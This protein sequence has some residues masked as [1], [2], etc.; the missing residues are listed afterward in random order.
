[1]KASTSPK[2]DQLIQE[3]E[4]TS[5]KKIFQRLDSETYEGSIKEK[6]TEK[7]FKNSIDIFPK[8]M[9]IEEPD[10]SDYKKRKTTLEYNL[11]DI[12]SF[13]P[14]IKP[15]KMYIIPSK[16]RL[17][18][19]KDLKMNKN[20]KTCPNLDEEAESDNNNSNKEIYY[21]YGKLRDKNISEYFC[22]NEE[23]INIVRNRLKKIKNGNIAKNYSKKAVLKYDE[24]FNLGESSGS[25]LYDIDELNNYSLAE[26]NKEKTKD[27]TNNNKEKTNKGRNRL[28]SWS[29]L[30]VLQKK[31]KLDDA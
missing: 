21:F 30:D 15:I 26:N 31:F 19:F 23:D 25:D 27:L 29:I 12:K 4:K 1:M 8:G 20:N 16:L 7:Q 13:V 3:T 2:K 9:D 6:H 10:D 22:K 5:S 17:N 18:R 24:E 11:K 28:N 14:R